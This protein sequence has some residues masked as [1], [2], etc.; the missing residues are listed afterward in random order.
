MKFFICAAVLVMLGVDVAARDVTGGALQVQGRVFVLDD[1]SLVVE[2]GEYVETAGGQEFVS[3][4]ATLIRAKDP[5]NAVL[6]IEGAHAVFGGAA[7]VEGTSA[8]SFSQGEGH[9]SVYEAHGSLWLAFDA[10]DETAYLVA[11]DDAVGRTLTATVRI[12]VPSARDVVEAKAASCKLD[13]NNDGAF[14]VNATCD[15]IM[16]CFCGIFG[17]SVFICIPNIL[18]GLFGGSAVGTVTKW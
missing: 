10:D 16:I 4:G 5:E 6:S 17:E 11:R 1:A 3:D 12:A 9:R 13:C 14:E 15:G 18:D 2:V 7:Q 8:V